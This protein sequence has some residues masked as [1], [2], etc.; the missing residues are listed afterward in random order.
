MM[1]GRLFANEEMIMGETGKVIYV[2]KS[3]RKGRRSHR[4]AL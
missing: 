1:F 3:D 4:T 2:P